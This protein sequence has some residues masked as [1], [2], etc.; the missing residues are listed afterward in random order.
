MELLFGVMGR[1]P[2]VHPTLARLA[3]YST[4]S[5]P[6]IK[7]VTVTDGDVALGHAARRFISLSG[8]DPR[9][10][11]HLDGEIRSIGGVHV[12]P[13]VRNEE[14]YRRLE[15]EH[16]RDRD[17]F[18]EKLDGSFCLIV[19]DDRDCS[20]G[21]DVAGTRSVYWWSRD[22]IVAFHSHL[23]DLAPSLPGSL[24]EDS[25]ALASFLGAGIYPPQRTAFS[26]VA[27]LGAG[28]YLQFDAE[29]PPQVR[30]HLSIVY[31]KAT[32]SGSRVRPVDELIGLISVSVATAAAWMQRPVVP[33]SGGL[34]SRY[35]LAE[36]A[37]HAPDASA[38]AT[39]T[40]GEDRRRPDSDALVA[41]RIAAMI[42]ASNTWFEKRQ[43]PS[44][45][46]FARAIYLSSGEANCAIHFPDD[47]GLHALLA[48]KGFGSLLR[49]DE[50]FGNGPT[51]LTRQAAFAVNGIARLRVNGG[52]AAMIEPGRLERMADAQRGDLATMMARVRSATATGARDEIRYAMVVR[53]VLA[54]YNRVKHADL[55]V[56]TPFLARPILEWLHATPD[57]MRF[58]KKLLRS[59]LARHF[60]HLAA[61][62]FAARSNLPNWDLRWRHDPRLV[63]FY[64][65]W[66]SKPGWLDVI[67]SRA[68]V[69]AELNRASHAASL[70][71]VAQAASNG[72]D[73]KALLKRTLPGRA[74]REL[75]IERR[76]QASSYER[77]SRLAVLHR[78]I[79]DVEQRRREGGA[80][81]V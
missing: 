55:E 72:S 30:D 45:E 47:H 60:P 7:L 50:C 78:L 21:V 41:P 33:L 44:P 68:P 27:H 66:C 61:L 8:E 31:E 64:Q 62:P 38:I 11:F 58:D 43:Y 80:R 35:L 39:I 56:Y 67:G 46:S 9:L 13:D 70:P 63:G 20:I 40:W 49:G 76:Y 5:N 17:R 15:V 36:F 81:H 54:S 74:M 29:Q 71:F 23:A 53:R 6:G 75:T 73:W 1:G 4:G 57:S 24:S 48:A 3:A 34:D 28:Q 18:W 51:L 16:R 26:Q 37:E 65:D 19:R 32:A 10:T 12:S 42:G 52:Y 79:G 77:I 25:G 69:L 14:L 2:L 59:A 22:G